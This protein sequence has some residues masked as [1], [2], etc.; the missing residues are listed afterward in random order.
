[1]LV[2]SDF[3]E[4]L[5]E[6]REAAGLSQSALA[7]A[8]GVS[9]QAVNML[10]RGENEPSWE[11]VRKLARALGVTTDAF[12]VRDDDTLPPPPKKPAPKKPKR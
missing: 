8:T 5:K 4:R 3:S 6:L 7:K 12:D 1:M 2:A 10:E 9:R 11:T